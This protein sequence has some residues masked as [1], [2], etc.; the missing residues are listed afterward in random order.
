M[1]KEIKKNIKDQLLAYQNNKCV[2]CEL[3]LEE[4]SRPEIEHI[5]PREKYP[6]FEYTKTNLAMSCQFCN[7]SSKKG[8]K[9]TIKNKN[10]YYKQCEFKIVH[11]YY[12]NVDMFFRHYG[13]IIIVQDSLNEIDREKALFTLET[14]D[15][16]NEKQI[17]ARQKLLAY[18]QLM[19]RFGKD[20][21]NEMIVNDISTYV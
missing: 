17:E 8:R 6:E 1:N 19:K 4:T 16:S 2:Y 18:E 21:L 15:L 13:A 14:F 3:T 9:D 20:Q 5:A 10:Q 11:P 12:D 7:S